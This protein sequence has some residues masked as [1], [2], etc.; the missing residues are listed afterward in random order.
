M[1]VFYMNFLEYVFCV[2]VVTLLVCR[3][4]KWLAGDKGAV[5]DD[6]EKQNG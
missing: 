2:L 3:I 1:E 5:R 6:N 4:E